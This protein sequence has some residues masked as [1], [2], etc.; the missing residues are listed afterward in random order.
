MRA[1]G[2]YNGGE[3]EQAGNVVYGRVAGVDGQR[4]APVLL[5]E[6]R[7][8]ALNLG[9]GLVPTHALPLLA[10]AYHPLTDAIG[11]R[12]TVIAL[13]VPTIFSIGRPVCL[14]TICLGVV[15]ICRISWAWIWMSVAWPGNPPEAWWIKMRVFGK[16]NRMPSEAPAS[17]TVAISAA[18]PMHAV[19]DGRVALRRYMEIGIDLW[20]EFADPHRRSRGAA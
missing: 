15:R 8:P 5:H 16:A 2:L 18:S 17:N 19:E 14:A 9:E 12:S 10:P 1:R 6:G 3:I 4:I 7:Q 20:R 13:G 11:V